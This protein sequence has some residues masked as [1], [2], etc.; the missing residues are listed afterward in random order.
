MTSESGVQAKVPSLACTFGGMIV[1]QLIELHDR[2]GYGAKYHNYKTG[3]EI[4]IGMPSFVDDC[5]LSNIGEKYE[6][7]KDEL[8]R[9]QSD[10]QFWN[11]IIR[12]SGGA[13]ELSKYFIQVI[14]FDF[15]E[16][17]TP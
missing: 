11:D 2:F 10:V 16:N 6:T 15:T 14:Y 12:L 8:N 3:K 1:S 4:I 5:H 9:M 13:L 7:L 17:K